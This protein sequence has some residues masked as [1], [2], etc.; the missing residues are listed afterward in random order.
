MVRRLP[1]DPPAVSAM[2]GD[3]AIR[4]CTVMLPVKAAGR[5]ALLY[6]LAAVGLLLYFWGHASVRG[7]WAHPHRAGGRL[8]V[9]MAFQVWALRRYRRWVGDSGRGRVCGVRRL[10]WSSNC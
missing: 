1:P 9:D 3:L 8:V 10:C 4:Y 7:V 6:G 5:S 2:V